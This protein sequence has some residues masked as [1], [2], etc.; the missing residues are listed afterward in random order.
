[1]LFSEYPV[2][3]SSAHRPDVHITR[4]G[5]RDTNT[6]AFFWLSRHINKLVYQPQN[7]NGDFLGRIGFG[8]VESGGGHF[9]GNIRS[10]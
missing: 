10:A 9:R 7:I 2:E 3:Q 6:N 4:R 8:K 1:M 5:R